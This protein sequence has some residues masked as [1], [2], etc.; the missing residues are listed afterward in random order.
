M[1]LRCRLGLYNQMGACFM[2]KLWGMSFGNP[3]ERGQPPPCHSLCLFRFDIATPWMRKRRGSWSS[4]ATRGNVK[5]WAEGMS[6]PSR[7][8]WRE[9][10]V[11]RWVWIPESKEGLLWHPFHHSFIQQ[12]FYWVPTF[13][14]AQFQAWRITAV[15]KI[16]KLDLALVRSYVLGKKSDNN[17]NN[18]KK[19]NREGE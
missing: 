17:I 4:S 9:L 13:S 12:L 19:Y 5:T 14:Q 7:S 10:F 15:N 3:K 6:G 18:M 8:P 16:W 2:Q 11:S 1:V